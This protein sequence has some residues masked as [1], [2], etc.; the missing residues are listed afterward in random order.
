MY[1]SGYASY[2]NPYYVDGG[3]VAAYYD[4]SQPITVINQQPDV[5]ATTAVAAVDPAVVAANEAP[6]SPEIQEGTSHM[7]LARAAFQQGDYAGASREIDLAIKAL[8]R[9]SALHEF[10]ALVF[11]A[12]KDYKQAAATLY[13]VLSAG[14]GWDWTTLGGMYADVSTYTE[15]LR[16]LEQYIKDNPST[17][18]A[19]FVL[20]YHY[21]TCGHTEAARKQ[22]EE[23]LKLQPQ[24]TLSAQLLK[25]VGGDPTAPSAGEPAPQPPDASAVA[26]AEP[27]APADIDASKI[28][29]KWSAKRKDG[30]SFSLDLTPDSK[31]T[32]GFDQ[33][34]KK[35]E[36]GGKYSVDGAILVLERTDGAQMPGLLTLASNG[37][38]FKLYGG[39]PDDPGLDFKK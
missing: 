37:F 12:T 9:D 17:A 20:A 21:M 1:S 33:G 38:N 25:L 6:P 36:F 10:R 3:D 39:P 32:W 5:V 34:G 22:Y 13:A 35:Q 28:V 31:F 23:V 11:F 26:E 15:Q 27:T 2:S 7:D 19:R 4:Y 29:G 8:P 30:A 14:P 16:E 24:D 18:D